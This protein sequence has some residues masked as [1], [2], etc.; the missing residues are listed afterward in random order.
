[1]NGFELHNIKHTS[2]SQ[3]NTWI[4]A[5]DV[6]VAQKLLFK[7][8]PGSCAMERGNAVEN[9][10]V[11]VLANDWEI[12]KAIFTAQQMYNKATA[13]STAKDKDKNHDAIEPM[14][15][16]AIEQLKDYGKPTFINGEQ[17]KIEL[18]CNGGD[19]KIPVIGYLDLKYETLNLIIDLK[20][21]FRLPNLITSDHNRQAIIYQKATGYT[22]KFLYVSAK[23]FRLLDPQNEQETL[24]NIKTHL[25]RQ[26][27]FL[28]VSGDADQLKQIVPVKDSFY[29]NGAEQI[30]SDL[31]G[32]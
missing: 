22:V 21:T 12:D 13:L 4:N 32:I 2:P 11:N 14:V 17:E 18:L 15:Q 7:S 3:L 26:E 27:A 31:Y 9:A 20:T 19:W 5:P 8:F 16:I 25:A 10:V 6:W 30:R 28:K 1:M 24:Q 23:D 29:W